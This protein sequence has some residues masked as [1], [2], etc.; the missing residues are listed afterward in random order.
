MARAAAKPKPSPTVYWHTRDALRETQRAC[1][2][3]REAC[4]SFGADTPAGR[5]LIGRGIPPPWPETL[6]FDYLQHPETR[7]RGVPALIVARQCPVVGL[8]RGIQRIFLTEDGQKYQ[9]GTVKMSLGS[10]AGGRAA[11]IWLDEANSC[12][13]RASGQELSA[14]AAIQNSGVGDL[15]PL[16]AG[17]CCCP[18]GCA[19]SRS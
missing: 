2:I 12:C 3:W 19:R 1:V 10:I 11:L 18:S 4:G 8:V 14:V 13:A 5:Y 7:E 9:P 16:P 15:Q 17:A 6:A